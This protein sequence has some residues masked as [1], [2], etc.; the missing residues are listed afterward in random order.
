MPTLIAD[1]LLLFE[2]LLHMEPK[3]DQLDDALR[4]LSLETQADFVHRQQGR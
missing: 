2:Q 1:C 3:L 4:A